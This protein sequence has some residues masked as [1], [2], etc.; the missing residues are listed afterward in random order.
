V[1][2][3]DDAVWFARIRKF[4]WDE[5]KREHNLREH[6]IDFYDARKVM[7]EPYFFR[8]SDRKGEARYIVYGF[9]ED[10]EVVIICTFR[11]E[12]CRLISARR[13][14]RDEREKYHRNLPRR[15]QA[16]ED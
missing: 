4:E 16:G 7:D 13:A 12:N 1:S 3:D 6:K 8:R 15:P 2:T 9:L 14:R 10:R 11:G 5:E